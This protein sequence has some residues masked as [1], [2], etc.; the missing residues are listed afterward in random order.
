MKNR[1]K[2]S[3]ANTSSPARPGLISFQMNDPLRERFEKVVA[4]SRRTKT[5]ILEECLEQTLPKLE[6]RFKDELSK[7]A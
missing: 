4:A 2:S 1:H 6:E 3:P 5:S 7:A